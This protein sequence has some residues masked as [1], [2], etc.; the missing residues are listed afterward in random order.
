MATESETL[1]KDVAELQATL[2]KLTKDVTSMS[3]A[4]AEDVKSRAG[5]ANGEIRENVKKFAEQARDK[6]KESA[7]VVG[8][9]VG[10]NPF[11]SLLIAFGA[12]VVLSQ[13]ISRRGKP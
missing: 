9:Q 5:K 4:M 7:E 8:A 1:K 6:G 11:R 3:Q 2:N 12:G 10:E 13:L